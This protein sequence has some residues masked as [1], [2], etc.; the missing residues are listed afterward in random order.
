MVIK[1]GNKFRPGMCFF[2][3]KELKGDFPS[4][5]AYSSPLLLTEDRYKSLRPYLINGRLLICDR[6]PDHINYNP[7]CN[8]FLSDWKKP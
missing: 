8:P 7:K 6:Y 2:C 5:N 3:G 1:F 4:C